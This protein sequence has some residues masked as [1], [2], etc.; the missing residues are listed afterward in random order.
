MT[1]TR[2][3]A[4]VFDGRFKPNGEGWLTVGRPRLHEEITGVPAP[5]PGQDVPTQPTQPV[6]VH[7]GD[8]MTEA[9]IVP[10]CTIESL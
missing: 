7:G 9:D 4:T 8:V 3:D 2:L 1:G 6:P 5:V 10:F